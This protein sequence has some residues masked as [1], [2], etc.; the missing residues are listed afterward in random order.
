MN[1][2]DCRAVFWLKESIFDVNLF[3]GI[4]EI[5]KSSGEFDCNG[6]TFKR[7][8]SKP[9]NILEQRLLEEFGGH[10]RVK[11]KLDDFKEQ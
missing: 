11:W 9:S 10:Q 4:L 6:N 7:K 5:K 8:E 2:C 1:N 3:A